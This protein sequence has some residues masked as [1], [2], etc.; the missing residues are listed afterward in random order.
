M[1]NG[2]LPTIMH[3]F[4]KNNGLISP[5]ME[6]LPSFAQGEYSIEDTDFIINGAINTRVETPL[7]NKLYGANATLLTIKP[8]LERKKIKRIN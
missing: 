3:N 1:H 7:I 5:Q 6:I 2:L 8:T 4:I